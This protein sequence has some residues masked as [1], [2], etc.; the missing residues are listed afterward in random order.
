MNLEEL[1]KNDEYIKLDCIAGSHLYGLNTKDSDVDKRGIFT[2]P[3]EHWLTL[4]TPKLEISDDKS[5]IKYYE[6]K[7]LYS[8]ALDNNPSVLELLFIPPEKRIKSSKL[9]D[10]L[11]KHRHDFLSKRCFWTYSGYAY[12]QIKRAKGKNKKVHNVAN[13]VKEKGVRWFVNRLRCLD[14]SVDAYYKNWLLSATNKHFVKYLEKVKDNYK[15]YE[16]ADEMLVDKDEAMT[17]LPPVKEDFCY[18]VDVMELPLQLD[19]HDQGIENENLIMPFR[20]RKIPKHILS[21]LDCSSVEHM[22]NL[23]RVYDN[24]KGVFRGGQ[25]VLTSISKEREW[26][27]FWGVMSFNHDG[28][29]KELKEYYSFWEWMANRNDARWVTQESGDMDYDCKN[30]SHTMRL[31]YE[32]DNIVKNG[33]PIITFT[34][35]RKEFLMD[36]RNGKFEYDYL[37]KMA[38]DECDRLKEVYENSSLPKK[39]P[40]HKLHKLYEKLLTLI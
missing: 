13:Y 14:G 36:I 4:N 33:E 30:M 40:L 24:G 1:Y 6:L 16:D 5:D 15:S 12:A 25:L 8:L 34:G 29:E 31:L 27:D 23:Y 22:A 26:E 32:A 19:L 7:K 28:F 38:E 21:T 10:E 2:W 37:L 20:P 18:F 9:Y 39:P 3:K 17:M 35:E 11:Y